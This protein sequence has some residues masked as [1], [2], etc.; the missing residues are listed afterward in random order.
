MKAGD[1][2]DAIKLI[3]DRLQYDDWSDLQLVLGQFGFDLPTEGLEKRP[4]ILNT[5]AGAS[6]LH[7]SE[8]YDY[9]P[10][11]GSPA[12]ESADLPWSAGMFRLFGSHRSLDKGPVAEVK[13]K[14]NVLAIDLFVAHEDIEPTKEWLM[15]IEAA[16]GSCDALAAFLTPNFL[17]SDWCDQ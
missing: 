15:V 13:E 2:V 6:D 3:A 14:L 12:A 16:L 10:S 4:Y 17:G 1:R 9:V 5:L 7:I 11:Q 8:I